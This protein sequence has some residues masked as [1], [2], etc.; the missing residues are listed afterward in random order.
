MCCGHNPCWDNTRD[1]RA[2]IRMHSHPKAG[3]HAYLTH[4]CLYVYPERREHTALQRPLHWTDWS[5]LLPGYNLIVHPCWMARMSWPHA[6]TKSLTAANYRVFILYDIF[7]QESWVSS[8]NCSY[9]HLF[10]GHSSFA[11]LFSCALQAKKV[12]LCMIKGGLPWW[13]DTNLPQVFS[14]IT[15]AVTLS[16]VRTISW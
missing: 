8:N 5:G 4:V 15:I 11:M 16:S 1:F 9:Q 14:G 2:G 7:W 12:H 10:A 3:E 13:A 6:L